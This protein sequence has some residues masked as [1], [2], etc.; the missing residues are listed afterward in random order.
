MRKLFTVFLCSILAVLQLNAQNRI[1]TGKVLG[2]NGA[3]LSGA[4]I[5]VVGTSTKSLTND[6][7]NFSISVPTT[8]KSLLIS[9]VG[10]T[11]KSISIGKENN[12]S[13]SLI[14]ISSD[15]DEVVV[16]TGISKQRRSEFTGAGTTISAKALVDRPVGSFDQLLQG[17]VPGL[18]ALT[19]SGAPGSNTNIIIRGQGSISGGSSPL[20]IIDGIA[21]EAGVFQG[22]NP[23]DFESLD[24][25]RDAAASSLYGSR[26][27]SGVIVITTKKGKSGKMKFSYNGQFGQKAKPDFAFKPMNTTQLLKAQE[28]YGKIAG[29]GSAIPG[30]FYSKQNPRYAT[31]GPAGQAQADFLLDSISKINSN[32][33]DYVFRNGNFSNHQISLSGGTGKT[34]IYSSLE[35]YNEEGTTPRTD[36][37][38]V[39]LRNNIDYAD[40]KFSFS[41]QSSFAYTKRN[42]QQSTT[43]NSL[44]NPFLIVNL[45]APTSLVF[46]PDGSGN[47]ATGVGSAFA[48]ANQ[49]DLTKYDL[50]Y[51]D[52]LKAVLGMT[53]S[54]KLTNDL[55]AAVT[56]GIDFRET[57]SSSYGSKLAFTR[58]PAA[59][60]SPTA[61]AGNQSEAYFRYLQFNIRPS[62]TY[63]KLIAQK[64]KINA[65][66]L[67]EYLTQYGKGFSL[68]GYGI[69]PR[70]PNTPAAITQGNAVNLLFANVGGAKSQNALLSMLG[71]ATYI[72]D[73]K[74]T[75]AG[76][77]RYDG[78]SKLPSNNRWTPFYSVSAKWNVM[79]EKFMTNVNWIKELSIRASYGGSGNS[80][81]FPF[82]DFGYLPTYTSTGTYSGL[83]TLAV[84]SLGNP[85]LKWETVYQTN[86]G[87]DF[88]LFKGK[89]YGSVDVY[90]K[91]TKDLFVQKQLTAEGT[92]ASITV[93][94]GTMQN[95]GVEMLLNYDII[96]KKNLRWTITA[97]AAYNKNTILD[98]G[99]LD[100]YPSGTSLISVGKAL[101]SIYEVKWAGVDPASGAPL[102]YTKEGKVSSTYSAS[103]AVQD[104]GTYEAP[105]KGGFG[106]QIRYLA[107]DFSVLFSWQQG[108]VKTDNLEY[109]VENPV[110][111]MSGGYNQ[112][113]DL[114]FWK[115]PGD[116]ASTPSPL[117]GTN[118]SS[119]LI[120]STNFMRLRDLTIGYNM[121]QN[122]I[123]KTKFITRA[124][125]FVQGT[126]LFIWTKWRGMDPEAGGSNIN[127]SEFPNP[128]AVT[129][130]LNITF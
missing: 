45:Q 43:T 70:T 71:T 119:K 103:Y 39:S 108:A 47:Y 109:F 114:N 23:N 94:A 101:G 130:G 13:I 6:A 111:F 86:L 53:A 26:G 93:N 34:T 117:Y 102:Y 125:F 31:L 69:D 99:G 61:L 36:M 12:I 20:Y 21:V 110:G 80:D 18:A 22:L 14:N 118:F 129:M 84:S 83:A 113:A 51:N 77:Y 81:N 95:K 126:N 35:L 28:D 124:R 116:I 57:Q 25:L 76:S 58:T 10:Y 85:D 32:W 50:N 100:S 24:V 87:L 4:T 115:K 54:Y 29:G 127:L 7:G 2:D 105:W 38:R 59:T 107:F 74:Y 56:T 40:D 79:K 90:D 122:L 30:W 65:T 5:L 63:N 46:K 42:F 27:S 68:T 1:I 91:R 49:L 60:T 11:T 72:Y 106:S 8:S 44:G 62:I 33:G 75:I 52:Q 3:P 98:L 9:Y 48:G 82:G 89:L 123:Q 66:V 64:H 41:L 17:Q 120:H 15:L 97:N 96:N 67:G 78:S 88:S 92:G 121:P 55:T 104:Y 37:K 19:L 16:S 112:S 128:R 73:G